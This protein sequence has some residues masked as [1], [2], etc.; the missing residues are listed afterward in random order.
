MHSHLLG[1]PSCLRVLTE[2]HSRR[3]QLSQTHKLQ[4]SI[5]I[6]SIS[7]LPYLQHAL[8]V[9]TEPHSRRPQLYGLVVIAAWSF[10]VSSIILFGIKNTIGL[11]VTGAR[12][13]R[14]RL[15]RLPGS[16]QPF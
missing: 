11:R 7:N 13:Q 8:R 9:L 15:S 14:F 5:L 12:P 4:D 10:T 6:Q 2:R 16:A 3:P 1:A